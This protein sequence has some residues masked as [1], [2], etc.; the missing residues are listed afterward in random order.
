MEVFTADA[1]HIGR[2]KQIEGDKFLVDRKSARD[3]FVPL[4][5]V[6]QVLPDERRVELGITEAEYDAQEWEHPDIF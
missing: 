3:I 5:L 6:S 1:V 4:P 2:V